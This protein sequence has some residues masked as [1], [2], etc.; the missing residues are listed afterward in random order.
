MLA[1]DLVP[2]DSGGRSRWCCPACP[3]C[4]SGM[5]PPNGWRGGAS[6]ILRWTRR[7]PNVQVA[8]KGS[9]RNATAPVPLAAVYLLAP[10]RSDPTGGV[11]RERVTGVEAALA[12]LGQAKVGALLGVER[13]AILL[14]RTGGPGGASSR[15]P[16][17]HPAR[18]RADR[19]ADF[20]PP[21]LAPPEFHLGSLRRRGVSRPMD[22]GQLRTESGPRNPHAPPS[23]DRQALVR[24]EGLVKSFPLRRPWGETLRH[25]LR[26]DSV[27][28]LRG[29]S[30]EVREGEFFGLLGPNGAGKTTLFKIL[31]TLVLPEAGSIEVA[32]RNVLTD[33]AAVRRVLTPVI[34]DER[35]LNWRLSGSPEPRTLRD[36]VRPPPRRNGSGLSGGLL[37]CRRARRTPATGWS[38]PTRPA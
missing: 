9:E 14:Q 29:V 36:A 38:A 24:I 25:P 18:L 23:G 3:W 33:A 20:P 15:L 32:G 16:A 26:R 4:S 7:L 10:V 17:R 34:A 11:Q 5:T 22:F 21:E 30:L 19:R 27:Q 1:D 28:V 35:S 8:W 2:V 31:A 13:R 12:L 37:E 6:P